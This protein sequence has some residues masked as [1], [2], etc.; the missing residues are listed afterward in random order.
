VYTTIDGACRRPRIARC[1]SAWSTTRAARLA[2][3]H[4]KVELAGNE[5]ADGL[6]ALLDEYGSVGCC[7]RPSSSR[8]PRSRPSLH[9]GRGHGHIE[10]AGM[11]WAKRAS[12]N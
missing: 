8:S 11:S 2:R 3:R 4:N 5:N 9:Q 12:T 6:E 7:S 1:A 10:W